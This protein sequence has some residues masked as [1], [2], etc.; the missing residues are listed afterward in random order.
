MYGSRR[1]NEHGLLSVLFGCVTS[2][3]YRAPHNE[4]NSSCCIAVYEGAWI[5]APRLKG[6]PSLVE[7]ESF[8][9]GL[10]ALSD[11][12]NRASLNVGAGSE[13]FCRLSICYVAILPLS[14]F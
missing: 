12:V 1:R 11:Y 10:A 3:T 14:G 5:S 9:R 8:D 2:R 13:P 7:A 4:S 6:G